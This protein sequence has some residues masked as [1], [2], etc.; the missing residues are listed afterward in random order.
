MRA[1]ASERRGREIG[2]TRR[3][4]FVQNIFDFQV[5]FGCKKMY[6]KCLTE[7]TRGIL[8]LISES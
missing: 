6:L 1:A 2:E 4:F 5:D 7:C 8:P 3:E